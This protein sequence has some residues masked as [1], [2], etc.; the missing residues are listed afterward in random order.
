M[1]RLERCAFY[2][3]WKRRSEISPR[4]HSLCQCYITNSSYFFFNHSCFFFLSYFLIHALA[5][6]P[7]ESSHAHTPKHTRTLTLHPHYPSAE[8]T[9]SSN[10]PQSAYRLFFSR[11]PKTTNSVLCLHCFKPTNT[12]APTLFLVSMTPY[13]ETHLLTE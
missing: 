4:R 1:E 9:P 5:L 6:F 2:G 10:C 13:L 11:S 3:K 12:P 8:W 7:S